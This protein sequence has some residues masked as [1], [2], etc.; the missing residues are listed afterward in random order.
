MRAAAISKFASIAML[1]ALAGCGGTGDDGDTRRAAETDP[2]N[3]LTVHR[4]TRSGPGSVNSY[5]IEGSDEIL[6]FDAQG[7]PELAARFAAQVRA[8]RKPVTAIVISHYHPD[9]FGG[10]PHLAEAFPDARIMMAD[11]VSEQLA[12]DPSEYAAG[13][14]EQYGEDF[15]GMPE[16]NRLL[17]DGE[18]FEVSGATV[19]VHIVDEA[20][21]AP[22]VMLSIPDQD[23]LL[24]S[25]LVVNGMHPIMA[26]ADLDSWPRALE[27][28]SRDFSGFTL[29]PGHGEEGPANLLVANQL[30]YL[31]YMRALV[32]N[33]LIDDDVATEDEISAAI[34]E[35]S[36]NYPRWEST[37]GRPAQLRRNIE[38][39]VEML[40]G[41]LAA[42]PDRA[43][44][45]SGD[46][47]AEE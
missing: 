43:R 35:I 38:A 22:I 40:G 30:A 20:E 34:S 45:A 11:T 3:Q 28:L 36:G 26:D 16:P 17:S 44:G 18:E 32:L 27:R 13:A 33:D 29:Y 25:D 42:R 19:Q 46:Q 5:W 47:P 31:N 10:L 7:T 41:D 9:H 37:T 4:S 8:A 24:A 21:A 2:V 39:M 14:A 6:I 12:E 23:L 1:L 15:A